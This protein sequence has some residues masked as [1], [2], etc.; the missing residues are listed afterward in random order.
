M[1]GNLPD[2]SVHED[3]PGKHWSGLPF[4]PPWRT[5]VGEYFYGIEEG[6]G[7]DS[8]STEAEVKAAMESHMQIIERTGGFSLKD[9]S[10]SAAGAEE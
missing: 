2:S 8:K 4:P 1:N 5:I 10:H 9:G 3:S 7:W 6:S